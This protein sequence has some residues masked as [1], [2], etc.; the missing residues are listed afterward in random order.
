MKTK[1]SGILTLLLAFV[2]QLSFAQGKT[3]SGSI[4]DEDGL[5]LPGVNIIVSGTSNGTQTDFDGNYSISANTGDVLSYSFVGYKTIEKT[6]GSANNISFAMAIDATAIDE[7]VIEAFRTSTKETSN[8]AS[9]T[10]T[11]STIEARPNASFVQTLQGQVAGLNITTSS[12]QPGANSTINLRG[13]SSLSGNTEPLFIIDG[14]PVDEDNFRSL[15]PNDIE[16]LSVLKDAG[17]TSIYGNR[18]ANGV[19]KITTK[20]GSYNSGLKITYTGTTSFSTL[21]NHDYNLMNSRE[22]LQLEKDFGSGFGATLSDT[23]LDIRARQ[24]DTNWLDVFFGTGLSQSHTLGLSSGGENVNSFTSFGYNDT[25]GILKRASTLKRFNF[26]NNLSGKSSDDK[27]NYATSVSINYSESNEPNSIGSG[28]INR[29]FVLGANQSVPYISPNAY[30]AGQGGNI[31]VVFANTPLFLLDRLDTYTRREDEIKIIAN[32]N[33][34]YKLT[35]DLTYG[36]SIGADFTDEQL[37]RVEAPTSFNAQL[38]AATGDNTPGFS[39]QDVTRT[40]AFNFNQN[41]TYAKTFN[42]KHG[43]EVSLFTE[44]FKAHLRSFGF[45]QLGFDPATFYPGDG[46]GFVNDNANDDNYVDTGRANIQNAGLFSYYAFADYDYDKRYGFS[47][48]VRRDASYRFSQSNRWGTFYSVAGRWNISNESFMQDSF[49]DVLKLRGSYGTTGNQRIVDAV[50]QFAYF[51][52]PDLTRDLFATGGQYGGQNGIAVSQIGNNELKWET[53]VQANIGLDFE[54]LKRRLRGSV[55]FYKKNTEDLFIN[56][57]IAGSINGGT[58][59]IRANVGELENR[60]VDIELH[61][62]LFKAKKDGGFN[63]TLNGVTNY[64]K[65]E[66][67]SLGDGGDIPFGNRVGGPLAEIYAAPY[68]G[69]NPANGNLLF[70]DINNN[71]TEDLQEEDQRATGQN[72]YPDWQGSFGLDMDYK[73]FFFTTQFNY[74]IGVERYDFD[75]SGFIDPTAIGQFRH[76]RDILRAWQ[77]PG[78]ITDIPSLNATNLS[79]EGLSDRHQRD[80]DYVRLR[81]VQLGY[82]LPS[83]VLD[84]VGFSSAKLF[85]SG[86]N[87]ITFTEWRG[88]DAEALGA[89]QNG[90]PTPKT[91]SVGLE[92]GF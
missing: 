31:P 11:A 23:E 73:N 9:T 87:L 61:Y 4:S 12:G 1:F 66:F 38:F 21:Q 78:D 57:P 53:V 24:A 92:L 86:E 82:A 58:T 7:V 14:V 59:G 28:A 77:N 6:V 10:I 90:Y 5:P 91:L 37:L 62:D 63:L 13:V 3:I 30:V 17:A 74:T 71:I 34:S 33:A 50:G 70:L 29:N 52:G 89:S 2:V 36:A 81:F 83:N 20:R 22:Q 56:A 41:L 47:A 79:D 69:V 25:E 68:V 8:I 72:I 51:S 88:F 39:D 84:K 64:N 19:V 65:Q 80:S 42:E 32:V 55:D 15:N 76:S 85:V 48:T 18:G 49:F 75:Y 43:L 44:Y 45:R 60:G 46:S 16:S 67:I 35:N 54:L 27:F 40:L 26:R